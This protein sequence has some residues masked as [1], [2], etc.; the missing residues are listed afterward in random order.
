MGSLGEEEDENNVPLVGKFL[1]NKMAKG[2]RCFSLKGI[3]C[4]TTFKENY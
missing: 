2:T 4:L 3:C 1:K